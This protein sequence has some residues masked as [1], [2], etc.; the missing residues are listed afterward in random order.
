M[1][2]E[3]AI[4]ASLVPKTLAVDGHDEITAPALDEFDLGI[5][6]SVLN[7]GGQTGRLRTVVSHHAVFDTDFH[8]FS[9][10]ACGS[11]ASGYAS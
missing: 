10:Y 5:A 8:Y 1:R 6:M 11:V 2:G 3:A 9:F 7:A 4:A